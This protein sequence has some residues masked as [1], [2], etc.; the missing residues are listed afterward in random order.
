[1]SAK[2]D[3]AL[4][5]QLVLAHEGGFVSHPKDPGG[6][7]NK[8]VTQAVYDAYR[9]N[10]GLEIQTVK[11][12]T[13]EE[14][15]EIYEQQYWLKAAC[16]K[17][18]AGLNYA[19]FD[20]AVNSGVARAIKDLQRTLNAN[21]NYYGVSGVLAVDGT[22]GHATIDAACSAAAVDEE[23]VIVALCARRTKFLKSL[24]TFSTFGKGWLR[25]VNG[26][27]DGVQEGDKGVVDY[28]V[29]MAR[30]D[31]TYPLKKTE[32]PAAIGT[33][34][35]E[36]AAKATEANVSFG[37]TLGGIGTAIAGAGVTGQTLLSA[38]ETVKPHTA[39]DGVIG[40]LALVGFV[41]LMLG[42][43]SLIAFQFIKHQSEKRS[44]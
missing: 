34:E 29:A 16:D 21:A 40:K 15:A 28:A 30:K 20:Y 41:L 19:V 2:S 36:V 14:V 9:R 11:R 5:L 13:A 25:R 23:E 43:I 3:Q 26:D 1:M 17:L 6:A 35:G 7:T 12:I 22:P 44:A 31:L 27:F 32:A 10:H 33:K 8:G 4:A 37:K 18:P 39:D 42:G 24:K 38:A